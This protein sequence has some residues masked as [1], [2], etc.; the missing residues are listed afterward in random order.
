MQSYL[1]KALIEYSKSKVYPFHMPGHKRIQ[2]GLSD[3]YSVDITEIDGFDDLHH[4][5]GI[6][7]EAEK[8]AAELYGTDRCFYLV[9]GSTCG[10]LAAVRAA[11]NKGDRVIVARNSH[12]AVYHALELNELDPVYIYPRINERGI[13]G[14]VESRQIEQALKENRESRAVIIT[15]PTYEGVVSDIR[16]ISEICHSYNIPLIVDEAHGAHFGFGGGFPEN[17]AKL[18][19]DAV[20]M[21]LHKTLP[22]FTQTALLHLTSDRISEDKAAEALDIFETSSPSYILMAGMDA[23]IR[24][25]TKEADKLFGAYRKRLDDFYR[26]TENLSHIHVIR[27]DDWSNTEAY[28]I[29]DGKV[30][31]DTQGNISGKKL[32]DI[33]RDKYLLQMEMVSGNFVLAMTSVMD[34]DEG[35]G[36]LAE[37]LADIDAS[38]SEERYREDLRKSNCDTIYRN[39]I[40][41]LQIHEAVRKDSE[42][43][44]LKDAADRTSAGYVYLYPPGIPLLVPGEVI[45]RDTIDD[46]YDRIGQGMDVRG[47]VKG[48]KSGDYSIYAVAD[49]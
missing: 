36:R 29:D 8:R 37:A 18:G 24:Q 2:T 13:Q 35:F 33:L 9:N 41:K 47:I 30:L 5:S 32:Y 43:I 45:G 17:A 1:D 27:R 28:D 21:S 25:L 44:A 14:Q 42:H 40:R 3:P 39:N 7:L 10:I 38:I 19:A 20:I 46:I 49:F 31:I 15:S 23:C 22:S 26:R 16:S 6:L 11:V 48:N 12:K 4:E 34:T